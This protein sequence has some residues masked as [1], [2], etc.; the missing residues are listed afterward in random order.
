MRYEFQ[1]LN[2]TDLYRLPMRTTIVP[3]PD[4]ERA[5][6][7]ERAF[8]PHFY[9]LNGTWD[10]TFYQS[11]KEVKEL[12][13]DQGEGEK[14]KIQVPGVWQ[15]QGYDKPQYTNVR[16]P[17]PYDPPFVP[18][19]TRVGVYERTFVLPESFQ[20]R[21]TILRFDGVSSCYYAYV[22]E[23]LVGFAKCP[24]LCSEFDIT[25][26]LEDGENRLKVVV[27]QYSDGTYLEDQDMW[28]H[29]GIFRDVS[30][31][32]FGEKRIEN[33]VMKTTL[34]EDFQD[35]LFTLQ[36]NAQGVKEVLFR[37]LDG[38]NA[39]TEG[40]IAIENGEGICSGK[41][42]HVKKWSAEFP[43]LYTL[44]VSVDGQ[45]EKQKIGFK[46]VEIKNGIFYVNGKNIKCKGVNRHDTHPVLGFYTP[47]NE[48]VKDI[49]L[50][51][52]HNINT[53]RTSHYPNDPRFLELCDE[54]GLYV[55]DETDLECHGVV[56]FEDYSLI[57]RDPK[58]EKQFV[59]RGTRMIERDRNHPCVIMWSLGN[60]A[61]YGCNHAAMAEAMRK[62][63]DLP[64]HYEGDREAVTSEVSS[65]MYEWLDG[66]KEKTKKFPHRPFFLCE[67]CHAMG[68]G[69]GGLESYWQL[70]YENERMMGGCVWE[71]ADHGIL[72]EKDGQPYFAYGGDFGEWPH[73]SCFCVDALVYPDRTP[74]TGLMEY[75]HVLRPV[76]VTML[77]EEKGL[78]S[79]W[80]TMDFASLSFFRCHWQLVKGKDVLQQ[81]DFELYTAAGGKEEVQLQL[82]A[83]EKGAVLNFVF[84]LKQDTLWA[85]S[86]HVV[87]ADQIV[88]EKGKEEKKILLP[89]KAVSMEKVLFGWQV[90]A[91]DSVASFDREGLRSL[92]Y[93]GK[94]IMAE[95]LKA[96]FWR[97]PT[98]NDNGFAGIGGK[99]D[100]MGLNRL[101]CRNDMLEARE[102]DN[103]AE[104]TISGIYGQKTT[105]PL[106]RVTQKYSITGDG[107]I[108][109]DIAYLPLKE[110]AEYL[111][112]L[113]VRMGI[114][115]SFDRLIW[116]GRG[117]M[118]SYPDK[119]T[120]A[121]IGRFEMTVDETHEPYVRPQEN[122]SHE[123][124][125]FA[126]L[127]NSQGLG[128]MVKGE[129][130]S[131]S[132]HH[133][134][135]EML[136]SAQH[137]Y[138]LGRDEKI[139]LLL[140]GRMGPLG[141][142]SCGPEP[143]ENLRLYL[144]EETA[145]RFSFLPFDAQGLSVDGANRAL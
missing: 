93:Q 76:R 53:V 31:I 121:L 23:T 77:D 66:M 74:H 123:D 36:V 49:Q 64:I 18:D 124:T 134:T 119:K 125:E 141:S 33:V 6:L 19:E 84:T 42:Q 29:C 94:E 128:L 50:M 113:G 122:G 35:G 143:E 54:Y 55:V 60:E 45:W 73:D 115:G 21:K 44:L 22:N 106:F 43:N 10:F 104:V 98:D 68:N 28:R 138:E 25:D 58:W 32:S 89:R 20:G 4:E 9:L 82:G 79:L 80:N 41:V 72:Q 59:S 110:I 130:F 101:L 107:A 102:T 51:K 108:Q 95:G 26:A 131:F 145:F 5:L 92:S 56:E 48:M 96:N 1:D 105:P 139:T 114:D 127:L 144:K 62:I 81:Q 15:L 30:L 65:W 57:A 90:K 112:R 129:R 111:P 120:G 109:L 97:A 14:G 11:W 12:S 13:G 116:Q 99:W 103:G 34:S 118:E 46:K 140:D 3:Y 132:A 78:I 135:P 83:Y 27:L 91:G 69:P 71:W 24:H 63:D 100:R 126:V 117:P 61:G 85:K 38:E 88:L 86:G 136:T 87:A 70:M 142:N 47:V 52:Q 75:K 8:S 17:I 40:T 133:Y 37:L 39:V 16:F 137:T 7:G 67:Y 2:C